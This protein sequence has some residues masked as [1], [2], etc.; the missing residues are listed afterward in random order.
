MQY[1]LEKQDMKARE[2]GVKV[3]VSSISCMHVKNSKVY[4]LKANQKERRKAGVDNLSVA[5]DYS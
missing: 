5:S 1:V 3:N 4:I 2:G